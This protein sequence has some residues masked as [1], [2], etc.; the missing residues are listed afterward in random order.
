MSTVTMNRLVTYRS[1]I[2]RAPQP[3]LRITA[4]GRA[5]LLALAAAPLIVAAAFFG[6]NGGGAVATA[7]SSTGTFHY[8]TV[9]SGESLWQVAQS[10][11]PNSDPRDVVAQVMQFNRLDSSDVMA[12][13]QLAIPPQYDK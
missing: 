12:G 13:Q 11:A 10:I 7:D 9:E 6:L 8:V 2:E 5:V 3:R 4:R 1:I